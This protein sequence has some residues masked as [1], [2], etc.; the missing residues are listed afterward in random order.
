M[1]TKPEPNSM[2]EHRSGNYYR[3]LHNGYLEATNTPV[4]IYR[5]ISNFSDIWVRPL[6][7]WHERFRPVS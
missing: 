3:V 5:S 7:E 1:T 4:V 2:W 6:S